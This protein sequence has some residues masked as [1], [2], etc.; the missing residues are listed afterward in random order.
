MTVE[1]L[2]K[3][4]IVFGAVTAYTGGLVCKVVVVTAVVVCAAIACKKTMDEG[5]NIKNAPNEQN[6]NRFGY[7]SN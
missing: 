4:I 2:K 3:D 5:N 1:S 7:S 6:R